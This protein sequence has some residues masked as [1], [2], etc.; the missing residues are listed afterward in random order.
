MRSPRSAKRDQRIPGTDAV[1]KSVTNGPRPFLLGDLYGKNSKWLITAVLI[2]GCIAIYFQ[3]NGYGFIN[4]DDNE[5]VYRN[6]H[7][8]E[9]LSW[10]NIKWALTSFH[11]ANWHPLT[12]LSLESIA[13]AFGPNARA[14]HLENVLLHIVNSVLLFFVIRR[15]TRSTW[16]S[17]FVAGVFALHPAHVESVAWVAEHKD[18]LSTAFWLLTLWFYLKYVDSRFSRWFYLATVLS[19]AFGLMAK[20]MLVTLPFVL[21]LLDFWPLERFNKFS[22][23]ELRP[24]IVEKIPLFVLSI[25]SSVI[26]YMAQKAGGAVVEFTNIALADR[27]SNAAVSYVWYIGTFFYPVNLGGWYPFNEKGIPVWQVIAALSFLAGISVYAIRE[28]RRRKYFFTGWFWFVGT[29]VPVIGLVQVGKQSHADRY[30][31]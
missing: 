21:L 2:L 7:V 16:R 13:S 22:W 24:L 12:W 6:P 3:V 8:L 28:A 14:F 11:A 29:L 15:M 31:Y 25:A 20:P 26:T 23:H 5:Y 30:T 1:V 4:L 27:V 18:V 9:G 19:F 10:E 17:G